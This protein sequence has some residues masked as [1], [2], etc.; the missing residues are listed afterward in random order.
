MADNAYIHSLALYPFAS[1]YV[2]CAVLLDALP[3]PGRKLRAAAAAALAGIV[4]CGAYFSNGLGLYAKLQYE[5]S[6]ALYTAVTARIFSLPD[7]DADCRVAL[8]GNAP[9]ARFD[10]SGRFPFQ[11]LQLPGVNITDVRQA[12]NVIRWYLGFDLPFADEAER[13]ALM[14]RGMAD[15]MP[16]W[17]YEGSVRRIED[18][19]VV[20]F[21]RPAS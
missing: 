7:F 10:V 17:P 18:L 19:V 13:D 5:E 14:Q 21:G 11:K 15:G 2:L 1:L 9:A 16:V 12:E 20:N 8:V 6:S 3:P 4:L